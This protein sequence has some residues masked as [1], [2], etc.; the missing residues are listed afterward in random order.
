MGKM[1]EKTKIYRAVVETKTIVEC[2]HNHKTFEAAERC[3][4]NTFIHRVKFTKETYI[5]RV[6]TKN[7]P[8]KRPSSDEV[9]AWH[10]GGHGDTKSM[11]FIAKLAWI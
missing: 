3:S 4:K 2:G 6:E 9:C 5:K 7:N 10:P 8:D 1:T 11:A